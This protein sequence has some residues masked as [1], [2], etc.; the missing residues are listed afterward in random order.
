LR[1]RRDGDPG[2][3]GFIDFDFVS[4]APNPTLNLGKGIL[5]ARS[6]RADLQVT[7][8]QLKDAV[9]IRVHGVRG[10]VQLRF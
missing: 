10:G 3:D 4:Q 2:S 5:T 1:A 8:D 7:S 6:V 9:G